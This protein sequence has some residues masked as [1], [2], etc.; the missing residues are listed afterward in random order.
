[1][2]KGEENGDRIASRLRVGWRGPE[3]HQDGL[4]LRQSED[5]PFWEDPE[6]GED[7]MPQLRLCKLIQRSL[8]REDGKGIQ[9]L[10]RWFHDPRFTFSWPLKR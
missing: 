5:L 2:T 7:D 9:F 10:I 4:Q 6:K 8:D 3:L 1:M